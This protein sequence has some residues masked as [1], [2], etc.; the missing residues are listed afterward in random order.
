M[1][2]ERT[3]FELGVDFEKELDDL[4]GKL[5]TITDESSIRR[6]FTGD[7]RLERILLNGR[8]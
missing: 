5:L 2:G 7:E 4:R 6:K 8:G 3:Y 1:E